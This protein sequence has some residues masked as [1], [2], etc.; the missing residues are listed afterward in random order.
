MNTLQTQLDF[1]GPAMPPSLLK[2]PKQK[3]TNDQKNLELAEKRLTVIEKKNKAKPDWNAIV[4]LRKSID[5]HFFEWLETEKGKRL[6]YELKR[7][8]KLTPNDAR[9]YFMTF[10]KM[11]QY[12]DWLDCTE[13]DKVS[14]VQMQIEENLESIK[15]ESDNKPCFKL[16]TKKDKDEKQKKIDQK[17]E[18]QV[19]REGQKTVNEFMGSI[20]NII[21]IV[22]E[23]N[24]LEW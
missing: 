17:R 11:G 23:M 3:K 12:E 2:T 24:Q 19:N 4:D 15:T 20:K 16:K 22:E 13:Y 8:Y 21:N 6:T 18:N 10:R 1:N 7:R 14:L 9:I 5:L